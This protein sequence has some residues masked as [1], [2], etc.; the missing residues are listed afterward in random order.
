MITLEI[1]AT[2]RIY[3]PKENKIGELVEVYQGK[4]PVSTTRIQADEEGRKYIEVSMKQIVE[5]PRLNNAKEV[6]IYEND[7]LVFRRE[8]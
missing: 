7:N 6:A 3:F 1:T 5:V 4:N 2:E 8:F